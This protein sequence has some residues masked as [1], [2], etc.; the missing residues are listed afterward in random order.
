MTKY[1]YHFTS[2][3]HLH[4]IMS[5][6]YL[7]LTPSNLQEPINLRF[8]FEKMAYIADNDD[9]KPVVWLTK[10]PEVE[11]YGNGL[12]EAKTV[13]KITIAKKPKYK[14]WESFAI[15]NCADPEYKKFLEEDRNPWDWYVSEKI[16]PVS[17][18][19]K[20]ENTQTGEIYFEQ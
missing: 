10:N 9:H 2:L 17:E 3:S 6:G 12:I 16:I 4:S 20:V 5:D 19:I 7:K 8:D 1:L 13:I 11:I 18:F 15:Q 14:T